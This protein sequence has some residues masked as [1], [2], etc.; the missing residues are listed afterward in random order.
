[1]ATLTDDPDAI[2]TLTQVQ[3][4]RLPVHRPGSFGLTGGTQAQ[5]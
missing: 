3:L 1:M 4:E 2:P 5:S